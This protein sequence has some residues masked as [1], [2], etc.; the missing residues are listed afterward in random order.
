MLILLINRIRDFA[1][2]GVDAPVGLM[3][4]MRWR[5]PLA[6]SGVCGGEDFT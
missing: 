3:R 6:K 1:P 4:G 5:L 2:Q